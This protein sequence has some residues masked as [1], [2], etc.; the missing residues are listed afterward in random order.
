M[1]SLVNESLFWVAAAVCALAEVAI[2]RG[3]ISGIGH[4][5]GVPSAS[6]APR[7]TTMGRSPKAPRAGGELVWALIPG[8][9]LA[10]VLV[11]TWRTMHSPPVITLPPE[12]TTVTA[13]GA[14]A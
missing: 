14:G 12:S 8:L 3:A 11:W 9:V 2:V 10:L 7:P 4:R 5:G 1:P 13:P 6:S